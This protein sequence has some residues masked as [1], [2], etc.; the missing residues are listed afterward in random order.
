[1][2]SRLD[3]KNAFKMLSRTGA[4]GKKGKQTEGGRRGTRL[5]RRPRLVTREGRRGR[6][7]GEETRRREG[8]IANPGL[9]NQS[10]KEPPQRR[11]SRG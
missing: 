6:Y 3:L 8:N 5:V 7:G 9:R 11:G 10:I 2:I 4:E 1:M